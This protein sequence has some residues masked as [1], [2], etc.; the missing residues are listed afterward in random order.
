MIVA[1][2]GII[3]LACAWRLALKG[4]PVVVFDAREAAAEASWAAA[5]MLAP[6]GE[7]SEDSP[8]ARMAL[9]SLAQYA[10]FVSE[11]KAASG[12]PIDYRA[13]G[14]VEVALTQ[15]ETEAL[16]HRARL[17]SHLGIASEAVAWPDVPYARF[18]PADALVDP[19]EVT[20]AL[21]LACTRAGVVIR[22]HEPVLE[23]L[24]AGSGVRTFRGVYSGDGVLIA[25][26]A[27]SSGL[28]QGLPV[29]TPVRGHLISYNAA[30]A[31][32]GPILRHKQTY[33]LQR[34]S[35]TLIAGTSTEFAGFDR[36]LDAAVVAGIHDRARS[37]LP[38]LSQMEPAAAWNGFRPGIESEL[39]AIGRLDGTSIWTAFGHYRNGIL[40]AP[41]TARRVADIVPA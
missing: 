10:D 5:G 7:I 31:L 1:G 25:A 21:R 15:P 40:L 41:E 35:G 27:W 13:C 9:A 8:L 29:T 37:L 2:A 36:T 17:Q 18:F 23:I 4:V 38:D 14:A 22:E 3:G 11:L 6:G 33:L 34:T 32:L 16:D 19:R 12:L 30:P 20:A 39:P 26:G 24:E 28:R